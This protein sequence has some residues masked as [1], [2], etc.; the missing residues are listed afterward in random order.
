MCTRPR[1][2]IFV[3]HAVTGVAPPEILHGRYDGLEA[4][5]TGFS[6]DGPWRRIELSE[7]GLSGV[8]EGSAERRG[9][10]RLVQKDYGG[11]RAGRCMSRAK[12]NPG[13]APGE[14][15]EGIHYRENL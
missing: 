13:I 6:F 5:E 15:G 4:I 8:A 10:S 1:A 12:K 9:V 11:A 2:V 7:Y 3:L 14:T